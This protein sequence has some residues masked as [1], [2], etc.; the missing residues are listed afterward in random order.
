SKRI[1]QR[2]KDFLR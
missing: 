1:V 2:I